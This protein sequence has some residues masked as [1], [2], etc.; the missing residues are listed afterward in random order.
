ML[1]R[2]LI[3]LFLVVSVAVCGATD[4]W[5]KGKEPPNPAQIKLKAAWDL[6]RTSFKKP[7]EDKERIL[8]EVAQAYQQII[9]ELPEFTQECAQAAFRAGEIYRTVGRLKQAEA[10]FLQALELDPKGTF[11]ARSLNEV[12]HLYRRKKDY[13]TALAY[14]QRV[15]GEYTAIRKEAAAAVTWTGKVYLRLKEYDRGRQVLLGFMEMFPEFPEQAVR[16]VD[17]VVLSLIEEGRSEDAV[18]VLTRFLKRIEGVMGKS[19]K[20]DRAVSKALGKMKSGKRLGLGPAA[21]EERVDAP[22]AS[23]GEKGADSGTPAGKDAGDADRQNRAGE[24]GSPEQ[25]KRRESRKPTS[26]DDAE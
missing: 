26:R 23:G 25:Q 17:R 6:K 3:V 13:A 9:A 15:Q 21:V 19:I 10:T 1:Q 11:A 16:N 4:L 5:S 12:G 22:E 2:V 8:L 14:Y 7:K 20:Q 24:S 18:A